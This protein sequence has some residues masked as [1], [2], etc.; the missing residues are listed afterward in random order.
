MNPT[1][2]AVGEPPCFECEGGVLKRVLLDYESELPK[3]GTFTVPKVPMEQCDRCG[4]TVI[5]EEG[6]LA[7]ESFVRGITK[8]ISPDEIRNFFSKYG[9]TQRTASEIT[10]Y[11]EKNFSRW[12]SG[13]AR[14]SESVS[15]F[16]RLLL[17]D[18]EAF[19]RLRIKDWEKDH[20]PLKQPTAEAATA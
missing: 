16:L 9:L 10:G 14:P 6:N 11:G 4:D 15:N 17:A 1:Q 18:E 2:P 13:K 3:Y 20:S 8:A 19:E 7:I 5:G 12:L